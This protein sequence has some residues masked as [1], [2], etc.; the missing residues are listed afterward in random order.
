VG[1]KEERPQVISGTSYSLP[2]SRLIFSFGSR[3]VAKLPTNGVFS[4]SGTDSIA[5]IIAY[6]DPECV[7]SRRNVSI[8]VSGDNR[9][10]P[11]IAR[12]RWKI[13]CRL[14]PIKEAE[15]PCIAAVLVALAQAA[16]RDSSVLTASQGQEVAP[17]ATTKVCGYHK[18]SARIYT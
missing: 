13:Q 5:P 11:P 7:R 10:N 18:P 3:L 16:A 15:D 12:L 14:N 8:K 9:P 1:W 17:G 4:P 6:L 2:I